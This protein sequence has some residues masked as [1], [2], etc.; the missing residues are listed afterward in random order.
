MIDS[1]GTY[2]IGTRLNV[3]AAELGGGRFSHSIGESSQRITITKEQF[4][5]GRVDVGE[6]EIAAHPQLKIGD[7]VPDFEFRNKAGA[8]MRLHQQRG[9]YVLV[10]FWATWCKVCQRR[11]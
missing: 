6:I 10:D 9:Q 8:T 2:D 11:L 5:S 7:E 4:D 1:P 3:R